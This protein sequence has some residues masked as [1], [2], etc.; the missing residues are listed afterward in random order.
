MV[1]GQPGTFEGFYMAAKA[2]LALLQVKMIPTQIAE[3]Q[4]LAREVARGSAG[5][6][7]TTLNRSR[8][9]EFIT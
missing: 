2:R 3:T 7:R 5:R 9:L 6:R 8:H 4:K 1:L